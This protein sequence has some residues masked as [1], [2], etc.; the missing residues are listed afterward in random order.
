[1]KA[2]GRGSHGAF[3]GVMTEPQLTIS[4]QYEEVC[5]GE[6]G[7]MHFYK[8]GTIL[9]IS[10]IW[11]ICTEENVYPVENQRIWETKFK[12]CGALAESF[13]EKPQVHI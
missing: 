8:S 4:M 5:E 7:K 6:L 11:G 3:V 9:R 12:I 10:V 13:M 1:M 2:E